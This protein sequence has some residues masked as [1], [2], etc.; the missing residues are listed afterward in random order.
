MIRVSVVIPTYKRSE[1]L[2]ACVDSV[3]KQTFQDL[4]VIV[5][6]DNN[7]DSEY[8]AETELRMAKYSANEK[9]VYIKHESNKN[10]A[11]ARNTGI[12]ASKGDI[13][14]LLDDDDIFYP[15][16]LEKQV[17]FLDANPQYDAVY[18]GRKQHGKEII[19]KYE[20]DLS[21]HLL[22]QTFSPTTP[23]LVFRKTTLDKINGFDESFKRHQDYEL[24]LRFFRVGKI[25]VVPDVLVEIGVN[26]GENTIQCEN[27]EKL[28]EGYLKTFEADIDRIDKQERGFKKKVYIANLVPVFCSYLH[29]KKIGKAFKIYFK[30]CKYGFLRMTRKVFGAVF[31]YV[32]KKR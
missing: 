8:R 21:K 13:I 30:G 20:G 1:R 25:G 27:L 7:P 9:V 5:V 14:A 23:T 19:G 29:R 4:E 28:K 12:R 16:K 31:S 3:L 17:A 10:G 18:C 26:E 24:L 2:Q 15:E 11:A 32:F 22:L 6:D